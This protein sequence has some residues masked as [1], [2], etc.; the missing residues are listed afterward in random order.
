MPDKITVISVVWMTMISAML[1]ATC[2]LYD[3]KPQE[4]KVYGPFATASAKPY[5]SVQ[6]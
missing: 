4:A 5:T 6:Y 1:A 2:A 3:H